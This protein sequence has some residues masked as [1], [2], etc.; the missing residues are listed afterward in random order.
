MVL[1]CDMITMNAAVLRKLLDDYETFTPAAIA[2][3]TDYIE[4]MCSIYSASGLTRIL[5]LLNQN[6]LEKTSMTYVLNT[7]NTTLIPVP[8]NWKTNFRNLNSLEDV[9]E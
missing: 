9:N 2:Y 6:Q 5:T 1:A 3:K 7:L 4:P 8:E